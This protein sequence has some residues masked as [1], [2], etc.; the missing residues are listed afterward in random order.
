MEK[1]EGVAWKNHL[2]CDAN[3]DFSAKLNTWETELLE[4][5]LAK[6]DVVGWLRNL[7]GRDWALCIPYELAGIMPFYPDFVIMR[8]SGEGLLVDILE[9]HDDQRTDTWAKAKGLAASADDHGAQFGRLIIARKKGA[10]WQRADVNNR[11]TRE[12]A[13]RMGSSSDLESLFG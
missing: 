6:S 8:K 4:T 10:Q 7:P 1:T 5:E 13:R 11:A 12:K 3:G 9:P 2:Y